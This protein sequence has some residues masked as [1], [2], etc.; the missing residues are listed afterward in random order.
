MRDTPATDK[1]ARQLSV[2]GAFSRKDYGFEEYR[3]M[4]ELAKDMERER[5]QLHD[6][7]EQLLITYRHVEP[8]VA[9]QMVDDA[10]RTG[11][12]EK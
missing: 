7:S 8:L 2:E 12:A 6:Y 1:L 11:T 9:A 10:L 4:R 3:A 5:N